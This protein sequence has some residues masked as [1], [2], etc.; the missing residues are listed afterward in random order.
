M[1][2]KNELTAGEVITCRA[3]GWDMQGSQFNSVGQKLRKNKK[4]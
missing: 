3:L 4:N 2:Q 1:F